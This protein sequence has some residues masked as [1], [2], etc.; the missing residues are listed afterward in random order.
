MTRASKMV[1]V[2][3]IALAG[4]PMIY[5]RQVHSRLGWLHAGVTHALAR[6]REQPFITYLSHSIISM[7]A[8]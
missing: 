5:H 7:I 2:L 8:T 3:K 6:S 4:F 1:W